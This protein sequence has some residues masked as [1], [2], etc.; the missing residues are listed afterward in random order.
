MALK[1]VDPNTKN[2]IEIKV[3]AAESLPL[4]TI[5]EYSGGTAPKGYMICDGSA[6]SRTKYPEL[7]QLIGTT[8]GSGDGST[9][10]NIP[11]KRGKI[12]VGYDGTN[13]NF[14]ALGKTGGEETHTIDFNHT[15]AQTHAFT[16]GYNNHD[17]LKYQQGETTVQSVVA[18]QPSDWSGIT[19]NPVAGS[20]ITLGIKTWTNL[21]PYITLNYII[22]VEEII[23]VAGRVIN[24]EDSTNETS[25]YSCKY[26]D[27]NFGKGGSGGDL[28]PIGTISLFGGGVI[29]DGWLKCDGEVYAIDDYPELY[30]VVGLTWVNSSS[31]GASTGYFCVPDLGGRVAI[32]ATDE[33]SALNYAKDYSLG[34]FGGS[35][36]HTHT[37]R[38]GHATWYSLPL[39]ESSYGLYVMDENG[40]RSTT[41]YDGSRVPTDTRRRNA[42]LSAGHT[43]FSHDGFATETQGSSFS[44]FTLQP[45]LVTNYII[46]AKHPQ[47]P[48]Q[49]VLSETLPVGT[50]V[51]FDGTKIPEGWEEIDDA[52]DFST[53]EKV[54]GTW[55][56]GKPLYRKTVTFT[57]TNTNQNDYAHNISNVN[58]IWVDDGDSFLAINDISLPVNYSRG[59]DYLYTHANRDNVTMKISANGWLNYP[60]YVTLKYTKTTD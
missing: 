2:I 41:S 6:I 12:G 16:A 22:K 19:S 40:V 25:T 44:E 27:E 54:I 9:T 47:E 3:K 42:A 18:T 32:G 56:N 57:P 14:N 21:Q 20:K 50:V 33:L 46:K 24:Q 53:T 5:L 10:F 36:K 28:T 60:A 51:N 31:H 38:I 43:S 49:G 48:D 23:P 4:G 11:D 37:I 26:L 13:A 35:E 29:P 52:N 59:T 39:S 34:N 1:Y 15:H 30:S 55:I 45:Y 8:Y 17:G 58:R 7:F